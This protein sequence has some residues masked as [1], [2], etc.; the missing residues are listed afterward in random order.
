MNA[1]KLIPKHDTAF[2]A[3]MVKALRAQFF[4]KI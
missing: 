4:Q 1:V 2:T 3:A